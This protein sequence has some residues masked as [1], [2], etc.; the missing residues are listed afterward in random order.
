MKYWIT[1]GGQKIIRV[2]GGR[3]NSFLISYRNRHLL[4]DSGREN[5]L[6]KLNNCLVDSGVTIASL[7]GLVLTHSHF[8]HA[9]NAANIK[10]RFNAPIIVH[11]N[12]AEFLK[13][14]DNPVI[15]GTTLLTRLMTDLLNRKLGILTLR[16]KP[17]AG[18]ILLDDSFDL[19]DWGFNGTIIHT[20]GHS[21]GSISVIVEDEIA[22]VGDAMFGVIQ[23]SVLPPFADN[24]QQLV[25]SWKALLDTGCSTFLPA[26]G[27]ERSRAVL[28][29]QYNKFKKKLET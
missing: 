2:L 25:E 17:V 4:V 6:K 20:P 9:E 21:P 23:G 29:N 14:G 1:K 18:D 12:E 7:A 3:C 28:Q 15:H 19:K 26:H 10:V 27:R 5:N 11:S 13:R 16:Y 24:L 8:D 22:I